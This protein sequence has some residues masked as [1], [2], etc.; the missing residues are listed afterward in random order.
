MKHILILSSVMAC[1][2]SATSDWFRSEQKTNL[3]DV[4]RLG[5]ACFIG[6]CMGAI[7]GELGKKMAVGEDVLHA[8]T[9]GGGHAFNYRLNGDKIPTMSEL[10]VY[11][12]GQTVAQHA[13]STPA[14]IFSSNLADYK[15]KL[16][17]TLGYA[18]FE[19]FYR[20]V[21]GK[22]CFWTGK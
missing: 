16:N 19:T 9:F 5:K 2:L 12:I 21:F 13:A 10:W 17:L 7:N 14:H 8:M 11:G 15:I 20:V 18:A 4:F 6:A 22:Y 1:S 3:H